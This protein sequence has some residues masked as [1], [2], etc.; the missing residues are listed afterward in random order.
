MTLVLALVGA[1]CG[2]VALVLALVDHWTV[3]ECPLPHFIALGP[4]PVPDETEWEQAIETRAP[5]V[6]D[7]T[8]VRIG[9][10]WTINA[11]TDLDWPEPDPP[12]AL[13]PISWTAPEERPS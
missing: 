8:N 9:G 4:P 10:L 12:R 5:I 7:S 11:R 1:G 3:V 6:V 2:I 13:P